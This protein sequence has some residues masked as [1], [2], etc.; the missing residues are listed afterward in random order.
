MPH[1]MPE[2]AECQAVAD[3]IRQHS[4]PSSLHGFVDV[5]SVSFNM[6]LIHS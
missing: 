3:K 5:V 4:Q 2:K 1:P 6:N